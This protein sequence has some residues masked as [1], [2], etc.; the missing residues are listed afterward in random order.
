MKNAVI[1]KGSHLRALFYLM[2]LFVTLALNVIDI[3]LC[4]V[5]F[6]LKFSLVPR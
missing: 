5:Y 1:K 2:K 6:S 3:N 4:L